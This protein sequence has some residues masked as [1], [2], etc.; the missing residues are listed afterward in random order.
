MHS[1]FSELKRR[2]VFQVAA[3]YAFVGWLLIQVADASFEHLNLPDW[4]VTLV[5]AL[6]AIGFP[7][8]LILAWAYD[9]TP[10]GV[11]KTGA[12]D[13]PGATTEKVSAPR[14]S[15]AILA[16][17]DMS[18]V[19]DQDYFC[20]GMAEEIINSLSQLEKIQVTSRTSSFR[21]RGND[22]DVR[23]IGQ[24][25]NVATVLEGSVR[26]AD[27]HL[28]VS[29]QL[30]NAADGFQ[31]WSQRYDRMMEDVFE[32]QDD[33]AH[34][35]VDALKLK[36]T[37]QA[38]RALTKTPTK[39]VHAYDYYL[40]GRKHLFQANREG[41]LLAIEMFKKAID[42]DTQ[43][44]LAYAGLADTFSWLYMYADLDRDNLQKA[45][46]ASGKALVIDPDL[47]EAHSARALALS[48]RGNQDE[49]RAEFETAIRLNPKSYYSF[50]FYGRHCFSAGEYERSEELLKRACELAPE[51]L[52]A[53]SDLCMVLDRLGKQ[54]E[55]LATKHRTYEMAQRNLKLEPDNVRAKCIGAACLIE[56][57][58]TAK[59]LDWADQVLNSHPRD[60]S[61]L[62]NLSC[63]YSV[64][65]QIP[66]AVD[67]FAK[68]VIAGFSDRS[69][70]ENDPQLDNIR[71]EPQ[72]QELIG[73]LH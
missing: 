52:Q 9:V 27:E 38:E 46:E 39:S 44:A 36:L 32:I 54:S 26:K 2:K 57:G 7:L 14:S 60:A 5:I 59:A 10:G 4:S 25:L 35:V 37:P 24:E 40:R 68:A 34:K 70:I 20:E 12:Q 22:L 66:K 23:E 43:F 29:V 16:F 72:F 41:F 21:Y 53:M 6:V 3:M 64:A 69:W 58:E 28:R 30:I 73:S 45:S 65:G 33:I 31:L 55:A 8:A 48:L 56:I 1:F 61:T 49:A 13:T 62:Y 47:A 17:A 51:E 15:I 67:V 63:V 71:K 19:G 18:R 50:L 11:Q 42:V